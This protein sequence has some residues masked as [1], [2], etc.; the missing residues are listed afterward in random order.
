[1]GRMMPGNSGQRGGYLGKEGDLRVVREPGV[2]Q[3]I[4]Q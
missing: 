3:D 4:W 1:M 2:E